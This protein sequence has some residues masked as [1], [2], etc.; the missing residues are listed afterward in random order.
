MKEKTVFEPNIWNIL[1]YACAIFAPLSFSVNV[2]CGFSLFEHSL[3][4]LWAC[5]LI[6]GLSFFI[7]LAIVICKKTRIKNNVIKHSAVLYTI[8]SFVLGLYHV[9]F[10][11]IHDFEVKDTMWSVYSFILI[12]AY[13]ILTSVMLSFIKIKYFLISTLI[14][15]AVGLSSFL[16]LTTVIGEHGEGNGTMILFGTFTIIYAVSSAVY[17]FVKRA[18]AQ[19]EN[20]EKDYKP[21]FD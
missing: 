3:L 2:I 17:F 8:L 9:M 18:F 10:E 11:A 15:Y 1:T 20:E 21:Q 7:A 4:K 16:V 5:A 19:F 14:Y 6:F 12:F 13:S